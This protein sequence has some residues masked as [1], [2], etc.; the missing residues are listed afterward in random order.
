MEDFTSDDLIEAL[1]D[2]C[3]MIQSQNKIL[4][5]NDS[6]LIDCFEGR[7]LARVQGKNNKSKQNDIDCE[8]L[9]ELLRELWKNQLVENIKSDYSDILDKAKNIR[10]SRERTEKLNDLFNE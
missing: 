7:L 4:V 2:K 1:K 8:M 5:I 6:I 9:E 3:K 10:I